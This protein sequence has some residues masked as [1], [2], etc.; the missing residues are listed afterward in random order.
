VSS[1]EDERPV[2]AFPPDGPHP[3]LGEGVRPR[4]L[5]RG[6]DRGDALGG[7]DRVEALGELG[8]PVADQ[9]NE[10]ADARSGSELAGSPT[11]REDR[12]DRGRGDRDS[13]L[14]QLSF[15]PHAPPPRVLPSHPHDEVPN[16]LGDGR[17]TA[18]RSMTVRPLAAHQLAVPSKQRLRADQE[19]RPSLAGE[20]PA[21]R[22]HEQPIASAEARTAHLALEH[23]ELM[24]DED[25]DVVVPEVLAW[26]ADHPPTPTAATRSG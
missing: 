23:S 26:L 17:P 3:A 21:E 19:R 8:V 4:G 24:K 20:H 22:R 12:P 13:E 1:T 16:I 5:E 25:L 15:D 6:K 10:V 14:G 11:L 2:Q 18:G 7:E 9:E